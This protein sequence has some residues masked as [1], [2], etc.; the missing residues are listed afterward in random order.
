[1]IRFLNLVCKKIRLKCFRIGKNKLLGLARA[2]QDSF[3]EG[4]ES[5]SIKHHAN[6]SV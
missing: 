6:M 4:T 2:L 3:M 1:M 5:G